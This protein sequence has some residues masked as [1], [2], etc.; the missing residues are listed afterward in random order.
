MDRTVG[1]E[2]RL[3]AE[4]V[5][6]DHL[7]PLFGFWL[8]WVD[9]LDASRQLLERLVREA[10]ASGH[11]TSRAV[12]LMQLAVTE[13]LAGNLH[14]ARELA[15]SAAGLSREL[16][17]GQLAMMTTHA[18][19]LAEAHLGNVDEA[20]ELCDRLRPLA[21][22]SGGGTIDLEGT[23]GLL[24]LSLGNHEAAKAR[25][26]AAL[27][28]FERVGFGEPGQFRVH[29]DAA[30]AAVGLGD[31][32]RAQEIAYFLEAHGERT[33]H[34]WSLATGARVG[35]LISAARGDLEA[36][37]GACERALGHHEG[38]QMPV[39]RARTLLV[40]GVVERRARRRGDAKRSFE[41][42]LEI[43]E[44]AGARLWA[45]RARA[46]LDRV[47]L[48]RTSRD[49]LTEGE[50]RVAELAAKGLTNREVAAA[51][52]LSPKTVDANL[53]RIYRKLGIKSRAELGARMAERAQA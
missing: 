42:A 52:Y 6:T 30:E 50:R 35:A 53:T 29:A 43:F 47:G 27:E 36:A 10:T 38:L 11:D 17:V 28:V 40:N 7:S 15:A 1:L 9:D 44:R 8:R 13:C 48:R 32:A 39:E 37:L 34:G 26:D 5:A 33:D 49:E 19:A 2:A 24:E 12:G 46:E 51:L 22:G 23:L 25:F 41:Q 3:S 4:R 20:R 31:V 45:E 16:D 18:L 14:L 21:S